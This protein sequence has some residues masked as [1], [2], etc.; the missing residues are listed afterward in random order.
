MLYD[1]IT[2]HR[3]KDPYSKITWVHSILK[4][5]NYNLC[6]CFFGEHLLAQ[7]PDQPVS[8]V[9]SEKTALIASIYFPHFVWIATGG[10]NGCKWTTW[11]VCKVLKGRKVILWPDISA[12]EDWLKKASI[13]KQL[14]LSVMISDLLERKA[15]EVERASG[16]D[17]ADFLIRFPKEDFI[18]DATSLP[19]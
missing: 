9:E 8:I 12:Y 15:T 18:P 3:V 14:G 17:L 5:E 13:L 16:L 2:G 11:D 10:K 7:Y 4:K 6:Q 1:P 19:P